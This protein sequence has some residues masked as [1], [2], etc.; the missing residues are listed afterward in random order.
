MTEKAISSEW[1]ASGAHVQT[2]YKNVGG[3]MPFYHTIARTDQPLVAPD[4]QL[5][6]A[7]L[8]AAAPELLAA[9]EMALNEGDDHLVIEYMKIAIKKAKTGEPMYRTGL[10]ETETI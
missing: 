9:C 4:D 5:K 10:E 2:L 6:H 8:I 7:R 3:M 1:I